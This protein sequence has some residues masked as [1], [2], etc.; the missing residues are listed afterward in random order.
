[1]DL[2]ERV[3]ASRRGGGED[4]LV[5]VVVGGEQNGGGGERKWRRRSADDSGM[6]P[7][8]REARVCEA[9]EYATPE[10]TVYGDLNGEGQRVGDR[11]RRPAVTFRRGRR[12]RGGPCCGGFFTWT[13][14]SFFEITNQSFA[15]VFLQNGALEATWR[16]LIGRNS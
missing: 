1:M 3:G 7:L 2:E 15:G 9:R 11:R 5:A 14:S 16:R 8:S 12:R 13:P 4:H 6:D 10:F